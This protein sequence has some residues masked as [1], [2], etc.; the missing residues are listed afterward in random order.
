[1]RNYLEQIE[2]IK[3]LLLCLTFI[4]S[5]QLMGQIVSPFNIRYQTYQKGGIALLSNL[6]ISCNSSNGNCGVYQNQIPPNGNHNQD[7]GV[8]AAYVDIDNS[9]N[10]WMSS[11]DSIDLSACTEVLWAGL[12][13]SAR[14]NASTANYSSRNQVNLKV[15]NGQYINLTADELLDVSTVP[16][17]SGFSMPGYYCFKDITSVVQPTNGSARFTVA[18]VV[19]QT[20]SNNLFG[21]W[22][23]VIVYKNPLQSMRNLTVFDGMAYVSSSNNLDIPISGFTTPSIGPVSFELGVV[24]Y[25]GDRSIQGDRLQFNGNGTFLDVP[26]PLRNPND[27]FNSSFTLNGALTPY[28]NP[29]YNNNLGCDAGIFIPDNSTQTYLPNSATFATVR[30]ATSQDAILPR[31]I[32]SAIDIYEPDLRASVSYNDIN[33]GTVLPGDILEYTIVSKNIGSDLSVNT[34]LTDTLDQRLVYL[35]G[36]MQISYGPN[37]GPKTD[38]QDVDQAE[39]I[40]ADNVIRARIGSGA[41]GTTG[42]TIVNSPEGADSTVLKFR[43]QLLDDCPVWQCGELLENKAYLF[44]TG[45]ISGNPTSNDGASDQTD[46]NGCPSQETGNVFVDVGACADTIIL[47]TDSVCVG[48]SISF[49]FPDSPFLVYQ[50]SGPNGFT[51]NSS[52]PTIN[53]IQL[54]DAGI[55]SLN[56]TYN[57]EACIA[58][59]SAPVFVSDNPSLQINEI[60]N[61]SCYLGNTGY[62]DLIGTG[63]GPFEYVWS[64][65]DNNPLAD[66]LGPGTYSIELIDQYG[67]SAVDTFAITDAPEITVNISV[68]SDY[69]GSAISCY[70]LSD[71]IIQASAN[72]GTGALSYEWIPSGQT[73][74]TLNDLSAGIYFVEV[75]DENQ[76][77]VLDSIEISEP[78][79]LIITSLVTSILCFGDSTGAIN[80]TISGGTEGY[81][82]LWDTADTLMSLQ[83]LAAGIYSLTVTDANGCQDSLV[84]EITQPQDSITLTYNQSP[85]LCFGDTTA[86]VDLF[87]TGGTPQY[88]YNWSNGADTEDLINMGAGNYTIEV[89]DSNGCSS[90]LNVEVIEPQLLEIQSNAINPFCQGGTQGSIDLTIVGGTPSY[91]Y[92]WNNNET[93]EDI[94]DL[95]A[96]EYIVI[97]VDSNGCSDTALVLITDPASLSLSETH[98]DVL[99]YGDSSAQIDLTV[100]NGT[101]SYFFEW[102]NGQDTEDATNVSVGNIFVNVYDQNNC[103]AFLALQISQPDTALYI[104]SSYLINNLCFGDSDGSLGVFIEGGESPYNYLWN[105]SETSPIIENLPVGVY[106]VIITDSNGCQV[107]YID[108]IVQPDSL[109]IEY[110]SQNILCFGD[111][112]GFINV[113]TIGGVPN[114]IFD[115][116]NSAQ[117]EDLVDI[118]AGEYIL[119]L[120]DSNNCYYTDTI[121]LIEPQ[122]T[123]S[124]NPNVVNILCYGDQT[125]E[126]SIVTQGGTPGYQYEWDNGSIDSLITQLFADSYQVTVTDENGCWDTLSIEVNQPEMPLALE[127]EYEPTCFGDS[128]GA[129]WVYASGGTSNYTY[130]WENYPTNTDSVLTNLIIGSYNVTVIDDNGCEEDIM[131]S[132]Y[133]P[134]D[135]SG[136]VTLEMPNIFTPNNDGSNDMFLPRNYFNI[137]EYKL[138]VINRW[139]QV[140]FESNEITVGWNGFFKNKECS[141]GVYFWK[142]DFSD[143]YGNDSMIHG[144]LTLVR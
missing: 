90:D 119:Q 31:I 14:V 112:T 37:T 109:H 102:S 40:I 67:C 105:N 63:N 7:G 38:A 57:G 126:I 23:I 60:A 106:S 8:I 83:N 107:N 10:T 79:S 4:V 89:V 3:K 12:Y 129:A 54:S 114:Y 117:T 103:G 73:A 21:A 96:G 132:V 64:H 43:V 49:S 116:S 94:I 22:S 124:I 100:T 123:I 56:V 91:T 72:G 139:G 45:D 71:G 118:P 101:P 82:Y 66:S 58:D 24:A 33:G 36:S 136:C 1:M 80:N 15:N 97:V 27:F 104:D 74:T 75:L 93:T 42:G 65:G 77:V 108:T 99:C 61:D 39:F 85:I 86:T 76:C 92:L 26:D 50:W 53:N 122:S 95:Y 32:T 6:A 18:N 140:M 125:G 59:T 130:L 135:L 137:N 46:I 17:N 70:G 88:V 41:N 131:I 5:Y 55:Y 141:E 25:E 52:N 98:T 47:Y 20:G 134:L 68:L 11:S 30:V 113:S 138:V 78:D 48:E 111:S 133:E 127:G 143:N 2:I 62:I 51:S 29:S 110:S 142:V 81:T 13:W 19:S 144:N 115:W 84:N 121:T 16:G 44:G 34:F 9:A 28:R 120:T 128:S 69:N 87:V 35:P